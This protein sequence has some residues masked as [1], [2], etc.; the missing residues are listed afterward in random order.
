MATEIR[1]LGQGSPAPATDSDL[2]TVGSNLAQVISSLVVCNTGAATTFRVAACIANAAM[3]A[4]NALCWDVPI[5]ANEVIP[6]TLGICL[7]E[8]DALTVR[9]ASGDVTF[10]AF[11]Q[12]IDQQ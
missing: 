11:G 12:E 10:T 8:T 6:L 1:I 5:G 3:S 2:I 4:D 7:D 9:S